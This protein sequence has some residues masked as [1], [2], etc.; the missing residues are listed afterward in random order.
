MS[1]KM[2]KSLT[3]LELQEISGGQTYFV[4]KEPVAIYVPQKSPGWWLGEAA[5][6]INR[7]RYGKP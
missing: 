4:G 2:L 6:S 1:E 5:A 7:R 3:S